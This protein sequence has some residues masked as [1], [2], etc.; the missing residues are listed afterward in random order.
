MKR[1]A[2]LMVILILFLLMAGL[3]FAQAPVVPLR[4]FADFPLGTGANEFVYSD[5]LYVGESPKALTIFQGDRLWVSELENGTLVD[6]KSGK[7]SGE[8][9]FPTDYIGGLINNS[10]NNVF[11]PEKLFI[12]TD[13]VISYT[14]TREPYQLRSE[15]S[16]DKPLLG[17]SPFLIH[18]Y[19]FF[20][21][22]EGS[23]YAIDPEGTLL[24]SDSAKQVLLDWL[25]RMWYASAEVKQA[26]RELLRTGQYIIADAMYYPTRSKNKLLSFYQKSGIRID[27]ELE[28][29]LKGI[30]GELFPGSPDGVALNGDMY[31]SFPDGVNVISQTG[32]IVA[33]ID[34]DSINPAIVDPRYNSGN[35]IYNVSPIYKTVHPNGDLYTL[36]AIKNEKAHIHKAEKSWGTDL[37]GIA[38][39]GVTAQAEGKT[40]ALLKALSSVELRIVRNAL[41]ALHGYMFKSYDLNCYFRGF[42]WYSPDPA[43]KS[44]PELL[45]VEQKRLLELIT[46]IERER[47]VK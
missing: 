41:F 45:T 46:G 42:S 15:K 7:I 27:T 21:S 38:R 23:V 18:D 44:D 17:S 3:S 34:E 11:T 5:S 35:N 31:I 25:E 6:L 4:V 9:L 8:I 13:H 37:I 36:Y 28:A 16:Y 47:T 40:A 22:K 29:K 2:E 26:H 14:I 30:M 1:K 24:Q 33:I 20:Y 19:V 39:A 43:V 12:V 10:E 32:K